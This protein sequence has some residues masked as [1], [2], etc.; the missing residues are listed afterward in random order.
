M[1]L[2]AKSNGEACDRFVSRGRLGGGSRGLN[3]PKKG[4][5]FVSRG[6]LGG[7]YKGP[8]PPRIK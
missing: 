6:R 4:D 1:R 7:G 5:K 3:L 8:N 2:G